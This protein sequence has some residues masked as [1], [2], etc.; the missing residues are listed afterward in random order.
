[1][2]AWSWRVPQKPHDPANPRGAMIG[3]WVVQGL[4]WAAVDELSAT[5]GY[6]EPL[7][8]HKRIG[9][10]HSHLGVE[11]KKR[12][13]PVGYHAAI[14]LLIRH[15]LRNASPEMIRW[16]LDDKSCTSYALLF[17]RL[18]VLAI[19]KDEL[20]RMLAARRDVMSP[21]APLAGEGG[22]D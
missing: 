5:L 7:T 21:P 8:L 10:H 17:E 15:A 12:A 3:R 2:V 14:L 18:A 6:I 13:G 4:S 11:Q 16:A 19:D 22:S 1:M 20:G 9:A